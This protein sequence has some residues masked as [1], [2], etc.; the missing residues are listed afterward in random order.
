LFILCQILYTLPTLILDNEVGLVW[1]LKNSQHHRDKK[2]WM[3]LIKKVK[4][5]PWCIRARY[6]PHY[7]WNDLDILHNVW[8]QVIQ[9]GAY[10][11]LIQNNYSFDNLRWCH[12]YVSFTVS[13]ETFSI[14]HQ[15]NST[16]I[17]IINAVQTSWLFNG[18][19]D[20]ILDFHQIYL[21]R[22]GDDVYR[23]SNFKLKIFQS[24]VE[25]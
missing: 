20:S 22:A 12:G 5:L 8:W 10:I 7:T 16:K 25:L 15:K 21:I 23:S 1:N 9:H 11:Y 13:V 24:G 3:T 4:L 19:A 6:P 14:L 2:R 17:Q 18:S